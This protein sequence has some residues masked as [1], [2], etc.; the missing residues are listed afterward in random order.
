MTTRMLRLLAA[1]LALSLV[2]ASC[3]DDDSSTSADT[4]A[5]TEGDHDDHD[6]HD[7]HRDHTHDHGSVEAEGATAP[8]VALEVTADPAGGINVFVE[9]ANFAVVPEAASA[10]HLEGEGHFHLFIDGEKVLR[11]YNEAIYFGGV[12]EGDVEVMV[13]LSAND[14]STYTR[15]GDP[16]VAMATFAVPPHAH[17]DHAHGEPESVVFEGA[18]P[19]LGITVEPDPKSGYNAFVTLD[20]MVLS[21][22][23][24]SGDHVPGEGHLHLSVNGQKIGRLYGLA[25]HIPVLPDGAVEVRIAAFTNDHMVYVDGDG[26]PIDAITTVEVG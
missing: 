25:T 22:Q 12:T 10:G 1:L 7:D 21:A 24:A 3:G 11:F 15:G 4:G 19:M 9:T 16:I 20:G 5:M 6:D 26:E 17:D 2:T 14:H 13:E 18:A 23:N 8:T